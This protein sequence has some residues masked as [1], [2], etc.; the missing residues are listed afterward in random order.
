MNSTS[1]QDAG[2]I[3]DP[4]GYA[5]VP[6]VQCSAEDALR[7]SRNLPL[8]STDA[9]LAMLSFT[10]NRMFMDHIQTVHAWGELARTQSRT[11][12]DATEKMHDGPMRDALAIAAR[13]HAA[14]GEGVIAVANQWGRRYG[15]LAFA[16]PVSNRRR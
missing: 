9:A 14:L 7:V 2:P 16:L 4:A 3:G 8:A 10:V 11:L 12:L 13:V 6:A 5:S 1:H 15:H